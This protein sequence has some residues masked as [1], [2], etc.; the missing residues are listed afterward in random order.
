LDDSTLGRVSLDGRR[1]RVED[2]SGRLVLKEKRLSSPASLAP[3]DVLGVEDPKDPDG[4]DKLWELE[5]IDFEPGEG[6]EIEV[7]T[8]PA[9]WTLARLLGRLA[10]SLLILVVLKL[11]LGWGQV[12]ALAYRLPL[13]ETF[14]VR[15]LLP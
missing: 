7:M 14:Y 4:N 8:S 13:V 12:A 10:A 5:Y 15:I 3:G 11:L 9:P 1:Q 6:G 2:S